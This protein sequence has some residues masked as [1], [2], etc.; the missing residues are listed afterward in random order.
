MSVFGLVCFLV[1]FGILTAKLPKIQCLDKQALTHGAICVDCAL[2]NC[3]G[4]GVSGPQSCDRCSRGYFWDKDQKICSDCD[5]D[6]FNTICL[7]CD[8]SGYCQ[9]C[10]F[11]FRLGL[12]GTGEEG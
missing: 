5:D 6:P 11:G 8:R 9:Q 4:C 2:S 1:T 7:S 12:S 10:N 3:V